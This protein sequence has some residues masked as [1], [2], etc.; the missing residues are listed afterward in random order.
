MRLNLD[1]E[2]AIGE[3]LA[4][5]DPLPPPDRAMAAVE[6]QDLDRL[7]RA[8]WHKLMRFVRG[9][10]RSDRAPD[11]VQHVFMRLA[12]QPPG[13]SAGP[14]IVAP[15]AYLNQA[16]RN[17]IRN[18]A[19][20]A[21]RRSTPLHLCLDDVPVAAPDP[22]AMLEARDMLRRFETA[23][24][25]LDDRTREIFLAHR[26]DGYSYGEIAHRTGLSVKTVEM[27]MSRAIA[28]LARQFGR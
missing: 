18:E 3:P 22:I 8:H 21:E 20:S 17:L 9:R 11:I 6:T 25:T 16:A 26:I 4:D 19:R 10:I 13:K 7:Y 28:F 1:Q 14:R 2:F 23:I 15:D 12:A 27:H 5:A 24:T